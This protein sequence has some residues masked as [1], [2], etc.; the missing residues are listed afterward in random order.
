MFQELPRVPLP[1][2]PTSNHVVVDVGEHSVSGVST[3]PR[4]EGGDVSHGLYPSYP[5]LLLKLDRLIV[6]GDID[7]HLDVWKRCFRPSHE[8]LP[9]LSK[10]CALP[11]RALT[12]Y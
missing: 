12:S 9:R 10:P 7:F 2:R 6:I 3:H 4:K 8:S 5:Q 1:H 11:S